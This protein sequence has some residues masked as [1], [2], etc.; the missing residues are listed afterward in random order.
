MIGHCDDEYD[1]NQIADT[2]QE[3]LAGHCWDCCHEKL[4][5]NQY[6]CDKCTFYNRRAMWQKK[7]E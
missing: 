7:E 1:E 5:K 2:Q 3:D 6:P 4:D